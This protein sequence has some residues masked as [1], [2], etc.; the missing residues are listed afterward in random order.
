MYGF[1]LLGL[2]ILW[3]VSITMLGG[4]SLVLNLVFGLGI[5]VPVFIIMCISF[6]VAMGLIYLILFLNHRRK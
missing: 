4:C 2:W 5:N 3:A 6:I 1:K